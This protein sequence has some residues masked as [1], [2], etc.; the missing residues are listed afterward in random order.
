ML[1]LAF[2]NW[3]YLSLNTEKGLWGNMNSNLLVYFFSPCNFAKLCY[4]S[5]FL[6]SP[7]LVIKISYDKAYLECNQAIC[8]KFLKVYTLNSTSGQYSTLD[9][10][11][12][13]K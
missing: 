6:S 7:S 1:N 13:K 8:I 3:K 9:I 4:P 12:L 2:Q 5:G 11:F 10:Y